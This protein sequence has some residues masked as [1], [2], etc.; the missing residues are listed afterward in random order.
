MIDPKLQKKM[1][2]W[3]SRMDDYEKRKKV[4]CVDKKR[5]NEKQKVF[6][7]FIKTV[8]VSHILQI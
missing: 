7:H 5:F 1:V 2:D 8:S 6:Y 4:D 3:F